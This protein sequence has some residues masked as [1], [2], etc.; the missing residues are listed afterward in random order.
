MNNQ[1]LNTLTSAQYIQGIQH[2]LDSGCSF[3]LYRQ[4]GKQHV[5]LVL[6]TEGNVYEVGEKDKELQGYI[7][8]PFHTTKHRPTLLIRADRKAEGWQQIMACL[9]NLPKYPVRLNQL[10]HFR[11]ENTDITHSQ[12]YHQRF[13]D[14]LTQIAEERFEKLVLTYCEENYNKFH[15][16]DKEAAVFLRALEA[17]PDAMVSLVYTPQSGRWI[18]CTPEVL[19]EREHEEWH[20]MSLA[21][22]CTKEDGDWNTKNVHE[23]D[24]VT[25]YVDQTL[26]NVGA[27]THYG[28][29][30]TMQIGQ[31]RHIRTNFN[32]RF[33]KPTNTLDI[34]RL[35]H[36]TPAVCG[37]PKKESYQYIRYCE[38]GCRNYFSG[39]QGPI[40]GNEEAHLYVTLR[41]AQIAKESTYY[42]AG[43]GITSL[44][45]YHEERQEIQRKLNI[46]K[47][48]MAI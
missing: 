12:F 7:F 31:L 35:L 6:Q 20:T 25:R 10:D 30:E 47:N 17:Y 34:V 2:L 45:L 9:D 5:E 11:A 36:P 40:S 33:D 14:C 38:L 4:P 3:A 19:L 41:C 46:L 43:G 8:A 16:R 27:E 23:Q 29:R 28:Q 26:R 22:T 18:G 37:F 32:F 39:Y 15:M 13:Q 42:H 21:G 24:V 1:T 48:L 44:S